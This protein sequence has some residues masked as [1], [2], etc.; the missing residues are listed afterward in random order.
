MVKRQIFNVVQSIRLLPLDEERAGQ[1]DG[2]LLERFLSG[3]DEAA[4]EALVRR[5]GPMVLGVCRRV[6]RDPHDAEDAFQATFLVLVRRAASIAR[7]ELLGNW[8]YGVAYRTARA[9]VRAADLRREKEMRVVPRQAEAD[10]DDWQELLPLLDR[11]LGSLPDKYRAP[12]VLCDLRGLSRKDAA[13]QLRLAEGT[14][15]SRL[16]RARTLLAKRLR[17]YGLT[18]SGGSL[19]A[20]LCEKTTSAALPP[21]LLRTTVKAAGVLRGGQELTAALVS[22]RV[23]AL[24]EGVLKAMLL[25][26]IKIAM[27]VLL[28]GLLGIAAPLAYRA[29]AGGPASAGRAGPVKD[30]KPGPGAP[31]STDCHGDALPAGALARMGTVRLRHRSTSG[32]TIVFSAD[33]KTLFTGG[34]DGRI[35]LWDL[36]TGKLLRT[37]QRQPFMR[38]SDSLTAIALCPRGK[39][40]AAAWEGGLQLW[41]VGTAKALQVLDREPVY[42]LVFTPDGKSLVASGRGG[43]IRVWDVDSGKE[44]RRLV[45]EKG[46]STLLA[47]TRDG[48]TLVS[49]GLEVARQTLAVQAWDLGTGKALFGWSLGKDTPLALSP[50]GQV[51][52]A[53]GV[54]SRPGLALEHTLRLLDARTGKELCCFA[55]RH[56]GFQPPAVVFSPDGKT[57]ASLGTDET[58]RWWDRVSGKEIRRATWREA[59]GF[60]RLGPWRLAFTPD[61]KTLVSACGDSL[62]RRWDVATGKQRPGP[63]GHEGSIDMVALSSGGKTLV[64][65][66]AADHT[67]RLWDVATGRPLHLLRHPAPVRRVLLSPDDKWVISGGGDGAIRLWDTSTGKEVRAMQLPERARGQAPQVIYNLALTRDGKKVVSLSMGTVNK[68]VAPG[69]SVTTWDLATGK[70][71][72]QREAAGDFLSAISPDGALLAGLAPPGIAVSEVSTGKEILKLGVPI[73]GDNFWYPTVFSPDGKILATATFSRTVDGKGRRLAYTIR[74]WE[75]ASG[76]EIWNCPTPCWG[77]SMA[78]APDG[79]TLAWAGDNVFAVHDAATGEERL[80]REGF[81]DTVLSLAFSPDGSRLATGLSNATVLVWDVRAGGPIPPASAK[82]LARHWEAL[83]GEDAGR[84]YRA[85]RAMAASP[86][87]AAGVLGAR[88]RPC[89]AVDSARL[90]T[91]IEALESKRFEDREAAEAGLRKLDLQAEPALREALRRSPPLELRRRAERLLEALHHPLPAGEPLRG[92][93]AV[94]ALEH[95]ATPQ[96]REILQRLAGGAPGGRLTREA[97]ASLDRLAGRRRAEP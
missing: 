40:L 57:V 9:A 76:K 51:L 4:F 91:L 19:A 66:S 48:R 61:G 35:R 30:T 16:A 47:C 13:R 24:T 95:V 50:D 89:E 1:S 94:A 67:V 43:G 77:R 38:E 71:L 83:A 32:R 78:F 97:K 20:V 27:V 8:L 59:P 22:A 17:R 11:E 31:A 7:R 6:L 81:G 33:S 42:C 18:V 64:S 29:R 65:C 69:Y 46:T 54:R 52:V 44:L 75:L 36:A 41:D 85:I 53:G 12:I 68:T 5:Y 63:E 80:R 56:D 37:L 26:K 88:L 60:P 55:G 25:S 34:E 45:W 15:S 87:A 84:A 92:V 82:D 74:V 70:Q 21:L 39:L 23:V 58:I 72:N 49:V 3:R 96:A 10:A 28:V 90:R 86:G 14:L 2:D 73:Q 62:L 79:K 93:R